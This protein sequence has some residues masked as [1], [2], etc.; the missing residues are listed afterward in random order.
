MIQ[1]HLQVKP[2]T[3]ITPNFHVLTSRK[4]PFHVL[5]YLYGTKYLL[6]LGIYQKKWK[7]SLSL[8]IYM[9]MRTDIEI[10]LNFFNNDILLWQYLS[11]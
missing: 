10:W 7:K 2:V 9:L 11:C 6:M 5:A 8:T 4:T 3:I 1:D